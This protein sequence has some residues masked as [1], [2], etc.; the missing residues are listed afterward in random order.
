MS[1]HAHTQTHTDTQ[2]HTH[3]DTHIQRHTDRHTHRHTHSHTHTHTHAHTHTHMRRQ[4][5]V[6]S[7]PREITR[8]KVGQR[9]G[10]DAMSVVCT[11]FSLPWPDHSPFTV[12]N[13]AL[14]KPPTLAV[15]C[16]GPLSC[17]PNGLVSLEDCSAVEA[18]YTVMK[19]TLASSCMS[20]HVGNLGHLTCLRIIS[21]SS[22]AD[23]KSKKRV[24][25]WQ[26]HGKNSVNI[27]HFF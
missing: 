2:T 25:E 23:I 13:A 6:P 8:T 19:D 18:M 14:R 7:R 5:L 20:S 4:S 24:G 21:S 15:F 22:K 10:R 3:T 17:F 16:D 26:I 9:L 1:W 11:H 27:H 12:L